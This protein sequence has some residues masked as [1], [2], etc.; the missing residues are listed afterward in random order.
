MK[1]PPRLSSTAIALIAVFLASTSTR[2]ANASDFTFTFDRALPAPNTNTFALGYGDAG[3][4]WVHSQDAHVVYRLDPA[5]GAVLQSFPSN[6]LTIVDLDVHQ[7]VLLGVSNALVRFET[8]TGTQLAPLG[9]PITGGQ[10]GLSIIEGDIYASGVLTGFPG[11]VRMG[12]IDPSNGTVLSST[13]PP[14]LIQSN[15]LGA[16]EG[17]ACYTIPADDSLLPHVALRIVDRATGAV[18]ED[19]VLFQS[20]FP[21]FD[22]YSPDASSNELFVSRRDMEEIWV[23]KF[24]RGVVPAA[25]ASWGAIKASYR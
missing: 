17:Y 13:A 25:P 10:R 6:L 21:R 15:G 3:F 12:R 8:T 5:T 16:I 1:R 2:H 19:H 7:G 14:D 18:I 20:A 22:F 11:E 24:T 23:Y 4:L 9:N